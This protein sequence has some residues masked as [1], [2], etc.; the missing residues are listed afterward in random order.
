MDRDQGTGTI[1]EV[2][3]DGGSDLCSQRVGAF[4]FLSRPTDYVES[5]RSRPS[6][7]APFSRANRLRGE[8]I[9]SSE[10]P[11]NQ[12][13]NESIECLFCSDGSNRRIG[14]SYVRPNRP[15]NQEIY[16]GIQSNR[17][18][19]HGEVG[20]PRRTGIAKQNDKRTDRLIT[21]VDQS[22]ERITGEQIL[23]LDRI[24]FAI[25]RSTLPDSRSKTTR[26]VWSVSAVRNA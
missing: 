1:R 18:T 10:S 4:L 6:Q 21:A 16:Q 25:E 24:G 14:T 13:T 2:E 12:P 9:E 17:L 7:G 20:T 15:I 19:I 26:L 3:R 11:I 5:R 23:L 8:P 22:M